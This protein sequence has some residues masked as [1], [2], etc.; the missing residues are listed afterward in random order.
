[1]L[2][3]LLQLFFVVVA[4]VPVAI[5][6][7]VPSFCWA[8]AA[9]VGHWPTGNGGCKTINSLFCYI[10]L[11]ALCRGKKSQSKLSLVVIKK[12]VSTR[13]TNVSFMKV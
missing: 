13:L 5:V 3:V 2:L 9:Q 11:P 8:A 1:M 7:V 10:L 6:V 4:L 12:V